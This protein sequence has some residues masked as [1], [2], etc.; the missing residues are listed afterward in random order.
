MTLSI[1]TFQIGSL[2]LT[3]FL[4]KERRASAQR[5]VSFEVQ[6]LPVP[7]PLRPAPGSARAGV[8]NEALHGVQRRAAVFDVSRHGGSA[9]GHRIRIGATPWH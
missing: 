2:L 1:W 6:G 9:G 3:L 4:I 8:G 5:A 7:G